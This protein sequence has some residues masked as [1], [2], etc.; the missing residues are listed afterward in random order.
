MLG[1]AGT[2]EFGAPPPESRFRRK[3]L[4]FSSLAS[5]AA[6]SKAACLALSSPALCL[7]IE[8]FLSPMWYS[9]ENVD[10]DLSF[11]GAPS[12][13]LSVDLPGLCPS[14]Q[15]SV[16][17]STNTYPAEYLGGGFLDFPSGPLKAFPNKLRRSLGLILSM[18]FLALLLTLGNGAGSSVE[19]PLVEVKEVGVRA[20]SLPFSLASWKSEPLDSKDR[21]NIFF[22][23]FLLLPVLGIS[24]CVNIESI[25]R[26][27]SEMNA[28]CTSLMAALSSSR[29]TILSG[30]TIF[31]P[32]RFPSLGDKFSCDGRLFCKT[33]PTSEFRFGLRLDHNYL[34]LAGQLNSQPN[35]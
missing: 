29:V 1:S 9:L 22:L 7:E 4:S 25:F 12:S 35:D 20:V 19:S 26:N 30:E 2:C 14:V 8:Y 31:F 23:L 13:S 24:L 15:I 11:P 28:S 18:L 32:P 6:V 34:E 10:P 27:D 3:G 16:R 33:Q 17:L 21:P 5:F